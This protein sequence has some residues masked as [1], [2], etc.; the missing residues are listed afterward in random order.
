L[1]G[2]CTA[3]WKASGKATT[4][5]LSLDSLLPKIQTNARCFL[6]R[7]SNLKVNFSSIRIS[8]GSVSRGQLGFRRRERN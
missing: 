3:K 7:H 2:F 5:L 8:A 6:W 1:N 4:L